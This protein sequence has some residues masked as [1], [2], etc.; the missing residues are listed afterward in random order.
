MARSREGLKR[1]LRAK[2]F[3]LAVVVV[4]AGLSV[5]AMRPREQPMSVLARKSSLKFNTPK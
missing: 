4:V 1:N 5:W 2:L 3:G